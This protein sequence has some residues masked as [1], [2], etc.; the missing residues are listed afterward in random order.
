MEQQYTANIDNITQYIAKM[1]NNGGNISNTNVYWP[2][3]VHE[4]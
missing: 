3:I 2:N 1:I 4:L